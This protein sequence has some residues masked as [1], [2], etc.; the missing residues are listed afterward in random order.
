MLAGGGIQGGQTYGTSD[1]HAGY[2]ADQRVTPSDITSNDPL[3]FQDTKPYRDRLRASIESTGIKDSVIVGTGRL[4]GMDVVIAAM[5]YTFIGGSMGDVSLIVEG[6]D[7]HE[8][9]RALYSTIHGAGRIMS[10][11]EAAGRRRK[12]KRR[13]GKRTYKKQQYKKD[14]TKPEYKK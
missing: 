6:V 7:S 3:E 11:T 4:D 5:E 10:R 8:S 9:R 14:S 12:G 2:P 1:K 13:G